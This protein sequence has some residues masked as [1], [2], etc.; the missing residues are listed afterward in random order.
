MSMGTRGSYQA[1]DQKRMDV[2]NEDQ[3]RQTGQDQ[4]VS[5]SSGDVKDAD[6]VNAGVPT[7]G[8]G[9]SYGAVPGPK[10]ADATSKAVSVQHPASHSKVRP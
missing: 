4:P 5:D 3:P 7:M 9:L 6:G 8:Q 2:L 1:A 10:V